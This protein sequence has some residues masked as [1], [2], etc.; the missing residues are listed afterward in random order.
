MQPNN[1]YQPPAPA[2]PPISPAPQPSGYDFITNPSAP[3]RR[4]PNLLPSNASTPMRLVVVV[5]GLLVLLI[6]FLILKGLLSGGGNTEALINVAQDQQQIIHLTT[7]ATSNSQVGLS[8]TNE[9]FAVTAQASLTSAQ[10]QLITY[11]ATNGH[12]VKTKTLSL[13]ISSSLDQELQ[14][15]ATNSTYDSTFK[16]TMQNQLSSYQQA[17]R[18]AYAQTKG[19]KGRQLLSDQF[20]AAQL[21]LQQL[22]TPAS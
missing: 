22:N 3:P 18:T 13:K 1:P 19:P 4:G 6:L 7:N 21:L 14:T 8:T 2:P 20:N 15:A 10:Q 9:N 12:K 11:L 17:L 16:Q 5:G